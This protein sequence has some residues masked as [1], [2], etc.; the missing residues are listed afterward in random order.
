[1]VKSPPPTVVTTDSPLFPLKGALLE[2]KTRTCGVACAFNKFSPIFAEEKTQTATPPNNVADRAA[3]I[4]FL[5]FIFLP[6]K[7]REKRFLVQITHFSLS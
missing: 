7:D 1:M 6:P 3:T 2:S 4:A 5:F